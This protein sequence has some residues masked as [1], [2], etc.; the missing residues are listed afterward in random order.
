M[1]ERVKELAKL[2]KPYQLAFLKY[3]LKLD[4][5]F[6]LEKKKGSSSGLKKTESPFQWIAFSNVETCSRTQFLPVN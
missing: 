4:P 6:R 3:Y 2:V 1:V 5:A